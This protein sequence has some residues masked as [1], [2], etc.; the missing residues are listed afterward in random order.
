MYGYLFKSV[1]LKVYER[2][3]GSWRKGRSLYEIVETGVTNGRK[4]RNA[5]T[6]TFEE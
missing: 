5:L 2:F 6:P 3:E 1:Y 4:T